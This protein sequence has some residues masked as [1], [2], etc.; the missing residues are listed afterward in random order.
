MS[1]DRALLESL[2]KKQLVEMAMALRKVG[3][4]SYQCVKCSNIID[5]ALKP[6]AALKGEA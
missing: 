5:M 6:F 3:G 4:C 2:T 1:N